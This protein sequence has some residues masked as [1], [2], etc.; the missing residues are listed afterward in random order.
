MPLKI[1]ECYNAK[2]SE[3]TYPRYGYADRQHSIRLSDQALY[4]MQATLHRLIFA[5]LDKTI[6]I[7]GT[8]KPNFIN[9]GIYKTASIGIVPND[10]PIPIVINNP[11]SSIKNAASNLLDIINGVIVFIKTVNSARSFHYCGKPHDNKHYKCDISHQTNPASFISLS[12]L[13]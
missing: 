12:I 8:L 9:I 1:S 5:A 11:T 10:V 2:M 3:R 7:D 6:I 13:S 4:P